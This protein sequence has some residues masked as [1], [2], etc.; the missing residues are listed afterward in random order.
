MG[1]HGRPNTDKFQ[2]RNQLK[3]QNN[4]CSNESQ[5]GEENQFSTLKPIQLSFIM[6]KKN[7]IKVLEIEN[8]IFKYFTH[9]LLQDEE[10]MLINKKPQE[11][12]MLFQRNDVVMTNLQNI[13]EF[14][15]NDKKIFINGFREFYKDK[16]PF[17]QQLEQQDEISEQIL[18]NLIQNYEELLFKDY[19]KP[20]N[21]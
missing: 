6:E 5:N 21:V 8:D 10:Y 19:Q 18:T 17:K 7:A 9:F 13:M 14:S 2:L 12:R 3:Y 15:E 1:N 20:E 11:Q 16:E 4:E